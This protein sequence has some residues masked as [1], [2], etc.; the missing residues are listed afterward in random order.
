MLAVFLSHCAL[1]DFERVSNKTCPM[2]FVID[3]P[4]KDLL[5]VNKLGDFIYRSVLPTQKLIQQSHEE[6][7]LKMTLRKFYGHHHELV[8]PYDVSLFKLTKD[9]FTTCYI[10]VCHNVVWFKYRTWLIPDGDCFAECEFAL[11]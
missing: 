5:L 2:T 7:R 8:Y 1:P 10:V 4:F 6:D 11:L 9:I 3:L